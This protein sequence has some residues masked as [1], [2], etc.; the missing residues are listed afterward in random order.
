MKHPDPKKH[1][2][3]SFAKSAIRIG[4]SAGV[5]ALAIVGVGT[6]LGLVVGLAL[7]YG[8]AE[9]VGVWEELV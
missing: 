4:S 3:I 7:G 5:A 1:Q 2:L 8:F 6:P 9:V